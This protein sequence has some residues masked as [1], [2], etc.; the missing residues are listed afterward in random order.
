MSSS[1]S[2]EEPENI[3]SQYITL[4]DLK[5]LGISRHFNRSEI[6]SQLSTLLA[7]GAS[8][9]NDTIQAIAVKDSKVDAEGAPPPRL[10]LPWLEIWKFAIQ[11][12]YQAF[13]SPFLQYP[14]PF[15]HPATPK[16][17]FR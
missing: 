10:C 9:V 7:S 11:L 2:P 15:L 16:K 13:I 1:S 4:S 5:A 17:S 6:P 3:V 12:T 14:L 8:E